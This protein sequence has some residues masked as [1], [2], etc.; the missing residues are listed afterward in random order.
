MSDEK[1]ERKEKEAEETAS[2]PAP[3]EAESAEPA[4]ETEDEAEPAE[5]CPPTYEEL[6]SEVVTLKDQLLRALAETEN[7]RRRSE[8]ERT[9]MSKY[10][11]AN[12]AREVL[13]VADNLRRALDSV[14]AE[15]LEED[16]A[17]S[18][19][20]VGVEMTEKALPNMFTQ[21]AIRPIEALGKPF[22]HNFHQAMFEIDDADQ[23]VG[24][25][26]KQ[27]QTG[28][29]I[30][31]RLLRPAM[32]GVA[33][34][35]PKPETPANA[36]DAAD[37]AEGSADTGAQ[38]GSTAYEKRAETSDQEKEPSGSKVDKKL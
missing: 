20:F 26:V 12:F 14:D 11:I 10:A 17:L 9:D 34:G 37:A 1:T 22:D 8:R 27:V 23:P 15:K 25:V 2:E 24:T 5:V 19:F 18:N 30:H 33:K 35:G 3:E 28:Y 6:Q 29:M 32:V 21:F 36:A 4:S 7:L 31:D 13:S 38:D 16:E